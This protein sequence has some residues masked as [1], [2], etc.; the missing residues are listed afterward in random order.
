MSSETE[1]GR[2]KGQSATCPTCGAAML[3]PSESGGGDRKASE[4]VIELLEKAIERSNKG[5]PTSHGT[6]EYFRTR[7][8]ALSKFLPEGILPSGI[9]RDVL[10]NYVESRMKMVKPSTI[11]SE[12]SLLS[13]LGDRLLDPQLVARRIKWM[14]L[15]AKIQELRDEERE[16]SSVGCSDVDGDQDEHQAPAKLAHSEG[17]P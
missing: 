4:T 11:G 13:M 2:D 15:E 17:T 8:A 3:S 14:S 6:T 5:G 10:E 9:D 1:S 16:A 7:L 12:L